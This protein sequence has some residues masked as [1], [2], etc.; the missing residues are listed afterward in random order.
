[1]T[2]LRGSVP[3]ELCR[4]P[5]RAD[6]SCHF[7]CRTCT[8]PELTDC[9]GCARPRGSLAGTCV[10]LDVRTGV[11]NG[12]DLHIGQGYVYDNDNGQCKCKSLVAL[13]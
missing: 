2:M 7:F 8:G 12:A 6:K 3:R 13:R 11:C 5:K 9:V 1:M 4:S 10:S